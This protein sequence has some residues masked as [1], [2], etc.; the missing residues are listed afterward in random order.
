MT[1]INNIKIKSNNK[2][3]EE[4]KMKKMKFWEQEA[5]EAKRALHIINLQIGNSS[6]MSDLE[7]LEQRNGE[8]AWMLNEAGNK[9][10][11]EMFL[12]RAEYYKTLQEEAK[13]KNIKEVRDKKMV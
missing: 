13:G 6:K 2:K 9:E 4:T 8:I 1:N 3:E 10:E 12:R 5:K 7:L 11:A